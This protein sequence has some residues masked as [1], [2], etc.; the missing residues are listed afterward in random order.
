MTSRP[1]RDHSEAGRQLAANLAAYADE[2]WSFVQRT[3]DR[4]TRNIVR[5]HILVTP[6]I[7]VDGVRGRSG[8]RL[9]DELIGAK[10]N[11]Y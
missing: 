10:R 9:V 7:G 2:I 6:L 1:F 3:S 4:V 11:L 8:H 5:C